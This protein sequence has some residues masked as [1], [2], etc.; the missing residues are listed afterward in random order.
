MYTLQ[1]TNRQN[2]TE[3]VYTEETN[4]RTTIRNK[5]A[6][7]ELTVP[8]ITQVKYTINAVLTFPMPLQ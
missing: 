4:S 7:K 3:G 1:W 8:K 5:P 2:G 6:K